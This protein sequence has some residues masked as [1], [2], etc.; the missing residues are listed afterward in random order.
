[1]KT[2]EK[3]TEENV[4]KYFSEISKIPRGSG[5]EKAISDYLLNFGK[6]LGLESIQDD[7]NNIIIKKPATKGYENAPTVIIQGHMDM[8]CEKN[9]DKVHDFTKD[10][11]ELVV[12][13]DYIYANG[14]TLGADDGIAVAYAM[15]ILDS[16][17]ISHPALEVLITTDEEAGMSGA[18]ALS[19]EHIVEKLS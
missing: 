8:V 18:M 7:A 11:I 15:A 16:N 14:T 17:N 12:K 13:D 9:K 6:S 1:M 19:P 5:N 10:P 4:F 2:L 3:L